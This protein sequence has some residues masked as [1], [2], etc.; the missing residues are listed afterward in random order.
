[1]FTAAE[2][3]KPLLVSL[4]I[5]V[6]TYDIDFAGH[7]N[8][9]VYVRWLEDLRMEMLGLVEQLLDTADLADKIVGEALFNKEGL[10]DGGRESASSTL[11]S[12]E[13]AS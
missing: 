4:D 3:R 12:R 10:G 6:Q 11:P 2:G 7:V 8:N 1:M 9:Q 5:R 13:E